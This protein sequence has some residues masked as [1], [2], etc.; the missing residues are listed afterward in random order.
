M[1]IRQSVAG[2]FIRFGASILDNPRVS[3][4]D[5]RAADF[6]GG[7][8]RASSG[9][10]VNRE[11]AL[12]CAPWF[13]GIT[14][15]A[16]LYAK[17]PVTVF[18]KVATGGKEV[19]PA[20]DWYAAL[21]MKTSTYHTPYEWKRLM[22][23]LM[24]TEGN[25]YA[26]IDR[27]AGEL[28]PMDS[29]NMTPVLEKPAGGGASKL[30]YVYGYMTGGATRY[31][32]DEIIH[33]RGVSYDGI[34]GYSIV[35]KARESLGLTIGARQYASTTFRN[36]ARPSVVL[37]YPNK[38]DPKAKDALV[39]QWERMYSGT[40]NAHRTAILDRG[41]EIKDFGFSAEDTQLLE[42]RKFQITEVAAFLGVP[43]HKLGDRS[44][45]GY[46]GL[47]QENLAMLG[48]T[49]EPKLTQTEEELEDK[50]LAE[51]EKRADSHCIEFDRKKLSLLDSTA[52]ANYY[53]TALGGHGWMTPNE[54]REAE[55]LNP[56]DD[57]DAV[58][59]P[60]NTGNTGGS[61]APADAP[62]KP[63]GSV[64][65]PDD[66]PPAVV[67]VKPSEYVA[68]KAHIRFELLKLYRQHAAELIT[69]TVHRCARRVLHQARA[70]A[71]KP[72]KFPDW[73]DDIRK[74]HAAAFHGDLAPVERLA[75][76]LAGRDLVNAVADW[77][78]DG[79]AGE[80]AAI[81]EKESAKTLAVAVA[82][83]CERLEHALPADAVKRFF[84]IEG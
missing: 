68:A 17:L 45:V 22:M 75:G 27:V 81:A 6:L 10:I 50:L 19:D 35:E 18:R 36:N 64:A 55:G 44:G 49:L 54:V 16:D 42:T 29:W 30:W 72:N 15:L 46:N 82:A 61:P 73:A 60:L 79:L 1:G 32:P 11:T 51:A 21:G 74:Q 34:V 84:P 12:A 25:A 69:T 70:A 2:W 37:T 65:P 3:L 78:L 48:D 56:Q 14:L 39:A 47:E 13:R 52:R 38:L 80:F 43:P 53:R 5:P 31:N 76:E 77:L 59:V 23:I 9:A 66:T 8:S 71:D 20:H 33:L 4:D 67:V 24:L 7:G 26:Y 40:E 83:A 62:T 28:V 63:P 57:M 41:L 58:P